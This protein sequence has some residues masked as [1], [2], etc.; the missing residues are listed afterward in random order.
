MRVFARRDLAAGVRDRQRDDAGGVPTAA[1]AG[2]A[3]V[4][5]LDVPSQVPGV[6]GVSVVAGAGRDLPSEPQPTAGGGGPR[7]GGREGGGGPGAGGGGGEFSPASPA[8]R[9]VLR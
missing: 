5:V 3:A 2:L 4:R 1:R 8:P 9:R 6:P 7:G